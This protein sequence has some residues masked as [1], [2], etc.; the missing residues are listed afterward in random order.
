MKLLFIHVHSVHETRKKIVWCANQ[1]DMIVVLLLLCFSNNNL[2]H[3]ITWSHSL[4]FFFLILKKV[5][6]LCIRQWWII[7]VG[8]FYYKTDWF[9][10]FGWAIAS[11]MVDRCNQ[12]ILTIVVIDTTLSKNATA[13]FI[14]CV[15]NE[16]VWNHQ[17]KF[18]SK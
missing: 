18:V 2:V 6:C 7:P 12:K 10:H 5:H 15:K 14:L 4:S 1:I 3:W 17:T 16:K 8:K 13:N 11:K 9:N